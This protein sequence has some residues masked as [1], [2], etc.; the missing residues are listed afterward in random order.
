VRGALII[1]VVLSA[2]IATTACDIDTDFAD[3]LVEKTAERNR[4]RLLEQ[5]RA[6]LPLPDPDDV[7][8]IVP[9]PESLVLDE[10]FRVDLVDDLVLG[11][12]RSGSDYLFV[13]FTGRSSALGN[14]AV[15]AAGRMYVLE[16]R[17]D[18][19]RVFDPAGE[20]LFEFGRPGQGPGDFEGPFGID[21]AGDRVHVY[22]RRFDTSIWDL[23][24]NFVRDRAILRTPEAQEGARL[25]ETTRG[26]MA[27][28]PSEARERAEA[29]RFRVPNQVIGRPDGSQIMVFRDEPE[30]QIGRISTPYTRVVG[31][32]EDGAEIERF[33]EVPEW[34][35]P[36][37]AVAPDGGVYVGLFGHLRTEHY[38]VALDANGAARWVLMTPWDP[39][40]PVRADLRVDGS[41]RLYVFPNFQADIEDLRSPVQVYDDAG[42][43]IGSGYLH[44]RPLWLHWQRTT[45]EHV[46]GVRL[47]PVS[48][49]WEVVRYRLEISRAGRGS[50]RR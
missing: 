33:I 15:D 38:V 49:E 37:I 13:R 44:R 20:F 30:E 6:E 7:P 3:D 18:V 42:E 47:N 28:T 27:T 40:I 11:E 25:E 26:T 1:A 2:A 32:F 34:A 35:A 43:L 4:Q 5:Q 9:D 14:V 41:G 31:R 22:H 45:A 17:A 36:S 21:V 48:E 16:T 8:Y 50:R 46:Y 23:D 24:G 10:E 12:G 19:V 29:R 39:E